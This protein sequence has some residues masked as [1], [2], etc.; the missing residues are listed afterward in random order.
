MS[1]MPYDAIG[2]MRS[3]AAMLALDAG[4]EWAFMV[5]TDAMLGEDTLVRL[6]AHDRPVV[7]PLLTTKHDFMPGLPLSS[8]V[9]APNTGLKPAVWGAMSVML[10]NTKVFNCLPPFAWWGHDFHFAQC[11]AHYGHRIYIDTDT[12]VETTRGP[13]R[14]LGR[15]WDD[16]WSRFQKMFEHIRSDDRDRSPPPD[17]DSVF[18]EGTVDKD[19]VYW[20]L[21]QWDR[22]GMSDRISGSQNGQHSL[23]HR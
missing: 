17:F 6:L 11:L 18:G 8:P 5:D 2:T 15:S 19:G 1:L 4:F 9:L 3:H 14:N 20:A 23:E 7:F 21:E 10:F 16:L 12:V 13:S 22:L